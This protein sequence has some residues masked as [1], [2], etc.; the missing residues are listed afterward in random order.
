[1]HLWPPPTLLP[2]NPGVHWLLVPLTAPWPA[3]LERAGMT[4]DPEWVGSSYSGQLRGS[5]CAGEE[6]CIALGHPQSTTWISIA[7]LWL[8]TE[9]ELHLPIP[10][11]LPTGSA[12]PVEAD[13]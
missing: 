3:D 7:P 6:G 9:C 1:M 13:I 10:G 11:T 2:W 8:Q 4:S 5:S 12:R